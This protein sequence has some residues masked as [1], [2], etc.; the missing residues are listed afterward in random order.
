MKILNHLNNEQL[1]DLLLDSD[2]KGLR[3]H[4]SDLPELARTSTERTESFW[5]QQRMIITGKVAAQK[6][7]GVFGLLPLLAGAAAVVV[8]AFAMLSSSHHRAAPIVQAQAPSDHDLLLQVE[9]STQSNGP[10]ALQPASLLADEISQNA[11]G[12][13]TTSGHLKEKSTNE[14]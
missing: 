5:R 11:T 6:K 4:I 14:N 12:A 8:L 13:A 2:E 10:E 1:T 7:I 9:E 3:H